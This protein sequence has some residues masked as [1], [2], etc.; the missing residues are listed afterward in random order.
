MSD[1]ASSGGRHPL[2]GSAAKQPRTRTSSADAIFIAAINADGGP[3]PIGGGAAAPMNASF[4]GARQSSI[5]GRWCLL[6]FDG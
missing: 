5:A 2:I 6:G 1:G 3:V 4:C